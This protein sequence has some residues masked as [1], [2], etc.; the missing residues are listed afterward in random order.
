MKAS[1]LYRLFLL[2]VLVAGF[3]SKKESPAERLENLNKI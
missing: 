3:V 2:F 1:P